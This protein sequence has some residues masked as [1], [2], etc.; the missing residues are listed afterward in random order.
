[1]ELSRNSKG[2]SFG[3]ECS[4]ALIVLGEKGELLGGLVNVSIA[5]GSARRRKK[6]NRSAR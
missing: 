1:L 5:N 3:N 4:S 2:N 6:G